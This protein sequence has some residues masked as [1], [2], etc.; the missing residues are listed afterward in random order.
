VFDIPQATRLGVRA[1]LPELSFD[2]FCVAPAVSRVSRAI[3]GS[4]RFR[5][6]TRGLTLSCRAEIALWS[7]LARALLATVTTQ[8]AIRLLGRVPR[9]SRPEPTTDLPAESCFALAGACLGRSLAR[10]QFLYV[11]SAP[12]TIV[13]GVRGSIDQ[14]NAHAWLEPHDEVD[15]D[16]VALWSIAR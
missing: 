8:R 14:L 5:D 7:L 9:R 6:E 13:I 3:E 10:S 16:F 12:H 4:T 11:R 1:G 2:W 15:A